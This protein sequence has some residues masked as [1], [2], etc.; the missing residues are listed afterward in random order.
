MEKKILIIEDD[1]PVL[2]SIKLLLREENYIA[3]TAV[4]GFDGLHKAKSIEPDLIIS[5][6][7]MPHCDGFKVKKIL[8]ENKKTQNI[9]IIFLTAHSDY[10]S[11]RTGMGL[12]ADDFLLKPYKAD[13]LLRV[14]ALRLEKYERQLSNA[15]GN[16][17]AESAVTK[18]LLVS[19]GSVENWIDTDDICF[20]EAKNQYSEINLIN[21]KII[22]TRKSLSHWET[23]LDPQ[24]FYKVHRS[25]IVNLNKVANLTRVDN[26]YTLQLICKNEECSNKQCVLKLFKVSRNRIHTLKKMMQSSL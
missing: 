13:E 19:S 2:E 17:K 11:F 16:K 5:D 7:S 8:N 12:G 15:I 1:L 4:D 18:K 25:H 24:L 23:T 9:P 22:V 14:I 3:F 21:K 20:I 26:N 6:I 10:D